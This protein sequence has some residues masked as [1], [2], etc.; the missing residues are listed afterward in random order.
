MLSF[1]PSRRL[2][3]ASMRLRIV[4]NRRR[5]M[6]SRASVYL[7]RLD[8]MHHFVMIPYATS[9][10]FHTATCC[11]QPVADSIHAFGVIEMRKENDM[12]KN[13]LFEYSEKLACEITALCN[14]HK[15]DSNTVYQIKKILIKCFCEHFRS[16]ISSKPCRYAFKI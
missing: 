14:E 3:M 12:A 13:L 15:I 2:G 11:R 4:W 10:Q 9:S 6:A 8:S 5:R 1:Y 16:A 7:R